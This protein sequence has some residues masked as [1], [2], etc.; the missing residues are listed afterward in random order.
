MSARR[1]SRLL[2]LT[3][4]CVYPMGVKAKEKPSPFNSVQLD[5]PLDGG[6]VV[7]YT[8]LYRLGKNFRMGGVLGAGQVD[9]DFKV[10]RPGGGEWDAHTS[11]IVTPFFGPQLTFG[12]SFVGVSLSYAAFYAKTDLTVKADGENLTGTTKGW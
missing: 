1:V 7:S 8:R 6:A 3:C 5:I 12:A 2:V 9:R 10:D 11:A 4:L